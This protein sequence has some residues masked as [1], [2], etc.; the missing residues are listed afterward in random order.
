MH[1]EVL[2]VAIIIDNGHS[3]QYITNTIEHLTINGTYI[4]SRTLQL[5]KMQNT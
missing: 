2:L 4:P 3:L 5:H 1:T